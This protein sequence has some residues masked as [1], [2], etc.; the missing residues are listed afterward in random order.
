MRNTD[1]EFISAIRS[2]DTAGLRKIYREFLPRIAGLVTRSG[3]T[4]EDAKDVFQDALVVLFE[5]C[6]EER[7]ELKSAFSTLLYGVC[8]NLWGNR[9]QKKSR[10]EVTIPDDPKFSSD[11]D[12]EG[13][14]LE[15]EKNRILWDAFR[16]IGADC[17]RL[18]ELFFAKKSMAEIAEAMGFSSVGYAKKRKFQCKEHLLEKVKS[19]LRYQEHVQ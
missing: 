8:R 6:R 5:K 14:I 19:D 15:E 3:G 7:F 18:L 1:Q 10:T 11:D 17:Q 9:L 12:L 13:A 16:Q 2:G 4:Y